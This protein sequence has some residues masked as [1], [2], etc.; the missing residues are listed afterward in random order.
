MQSANVLFNLRHK[1]SEFIRNK[2]KLIIL[3]KYNFYLL[4]K[5]KLKNKIY[6]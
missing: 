5:F 2:N 1:T 3:I 4:N 6:S